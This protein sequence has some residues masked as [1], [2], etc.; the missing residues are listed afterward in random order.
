[1]IF[2][3]ANSDDLRLDIAERD[4]I[5]DSGS[6]NAAVFSLSS[7]RHAAYRGAVQ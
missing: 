7:I 4:N 6:I 2:P 1:M 5:D 3:L